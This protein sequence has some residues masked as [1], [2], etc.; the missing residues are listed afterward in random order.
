MLTPAQSVLGAIQ[1][2]RVVD[3]TIRSGTIVG[4]TCT[5][6]ILLFL[7]QPLGTSKIG[8][9]FAPIVIIWLLFNFCFGIYNLAQFDHSVLKAFSPYYAG[10]FFVR[11]G[12][13]GWKMLGGI[14][15]S[16]TG[17]EALFADL[18]AFSKR[19]IRF[20]WI[21]FGWPCLM[22]AYIGQA[23]Y[24]S[25]NKGAYTLPFFNSVPPGM[26]Y[27]SLVIAI[28]AAIVASQTMITATFQVC[29]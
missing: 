26:F 19:S 4:V 23:A 3:D 11:N 9:L 20:S 12:T 21:V 6:L 28:L 10:S 7:M 1:G 17:V 29:L 16:F 13:E 18:G 2:L 5:I 15:L 27:P 14:L 25:R 22:M 8:T 24:I